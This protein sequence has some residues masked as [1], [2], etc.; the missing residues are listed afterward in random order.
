MHPQGRQISFTIEK[1]HVAASI[2]PR[3]G[4]FLKQGMGFFRIRITVQKRESRGPI[5]AD[6]RYSDAYLVL[7]T[8]MG[9]NQPP[10]IAR[11]ALR[12]SW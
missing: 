10:N 7:L 3:P 4:E 1:L 8:G 11:T 5:A 2:R 12:I 9:G 6:N